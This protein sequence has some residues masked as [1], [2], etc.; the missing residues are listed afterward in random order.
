MSDVVLRVNDLRKSFVLHTIDGRRV[1][2]LRGVD[3]EVHA[4]EHVA[5]AGSS[6]AG[7]SSLLKCIYRTYEPSSGKVELR[8]FSGATIELT[9]L[10][11]QEMARVRGRDIGYVSQ[12]LRA[13]PRR[14]ALDV[15]TRAGVSR[16]LSRSAAREAAAESLRRLNIDEK[17]WDVHASVLSGGEKQ[18]INL[19]AGTISAPRVLLLDE[20]VSALD[21]SNREAALDLIADLTTHGVAVLAVFHDVEA[22]ERL[23]S[24]IVLMRDGR[25]EMAGHPEMILNYLT[26]GVRT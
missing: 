26:Q 4:G 24:R 1:E 18:R 5:L 11:D 23:A 7:K 20:P 2:A 25:I 22:M 14:G 19:A 12:F 3:L 16:G 13:E 15:V 6:G 8:N 21:P 9:G 10:S 17:L